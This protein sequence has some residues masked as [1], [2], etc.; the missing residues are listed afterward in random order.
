MKKMILAEFEGMYENNQPHASAI[1]R[2]QARDGLDYREEAGVKI[3][4]IP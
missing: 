3:V 4:S 1:E 2:L